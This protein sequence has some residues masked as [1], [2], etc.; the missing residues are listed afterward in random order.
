MDQVA[1]FEKREKLVGGLGCIVLCRSTSSDCSKSR[2]MRRKVAS[3]VVV[4][5]NPEGKTSCLFARELGRSKGESG[6][7]YRFCGQARSK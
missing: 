7:R 1:S 6:L 2:S 5:L 4:M 3:G